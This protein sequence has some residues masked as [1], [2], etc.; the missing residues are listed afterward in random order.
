M[1][2][3]KH[4]SQKENEEKYTRSGSLLFQS[5]V[6]VPHVASVQIS[7]RAM[8]SGKSRVVPGVY[9][10]KEEKGDVTF[11]ASRPSAISTVSASAFFCLAAYIAG[12]APSCE[13]ICYFRHRGSRQLLIFVAAFEV[14]SLCLLLYLLF[15]TSYLAPASHHPLGDF[16]PSFLSYGGAVSRAVVAIPRRDHAERTRT[17]SY[18]LSVYAP[19]KERSE[20]FLFRHCASCSARSVTA[21]VFPERK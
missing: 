6:C 7:I 13:T 18:F 15:L 3:Q 4:N 21:G 14:L 20:T 1:P 2:A 12:S 17:C 9:E 5:L 10:R 16:P 11:T 8:L 19:E